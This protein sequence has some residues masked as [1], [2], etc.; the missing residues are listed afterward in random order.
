[1]TE[2][3]ASAQIHVDTA[4]RASGVP[5]YVQKFLLGA[6]LLAAAVTGLWFFFALKKRL[7]GKKTDS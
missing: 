7:T 5:Y 3:I 4:R 6:I 1:M 2:K